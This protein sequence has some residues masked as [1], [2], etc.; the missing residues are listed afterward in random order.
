MFKHSFLH[1]I[2]SFCFF[3]C[4]TAP[5][6]LKPNWTP[7]PLPTSVPSSSTPTTTQ[8][9]I[10]SSGSSTPSSVSPN[11][12]HQSA[13]A[14]RTFAEFNQTAS[15]VCV[16]GL[17]VCKHMNVCA[18][19]CGAQILHLLNKYFLMVST[20]TQLYVGLTLVIM[21]LILSAAVLIY[22]RRTASK[23]K[24]EKTG[25]SSEQPPV[26]VDLILWSVFQDLLRKQSMPMS[27]RWVWVN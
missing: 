19:L 12:T 2:L 15:L 26:T 8:S 23:A 11:T 1:L 4:L 6:T 21:V 9:L 10:S 27:Q 20:G 22:C 25:S 7:G 18:C 24:G 3:S 14:Q 17:T 13:A 5:T 16:H